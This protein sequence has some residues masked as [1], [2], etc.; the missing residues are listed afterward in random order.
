MSTCDSPL[1][2]GSCLHLWK[3]SIDGIGGVI[4]CNVMGIL[5]HSP[6]FNDTLLPSFLFWCHV[7]LCIRPS[8][9]LLIPQ[10]MKSWVE[11]RNETSI[12]ANTGVLIKAWLNDTY[13]TQ[14]GYSIAWC[15]HRSSLR[16]QCEV[17]KYSY[18]FGDLKYQSRI[19]PIIVALWYL[20]WKAF[21]CWR[22]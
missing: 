19:A 4:C 6:M 13:I 12:S 2:C 3:Y 21:E 7:S 20:R 11:P 17:A 22:Q 14:K 16:L 10:V 5:L 8:C 1:D 9:C 15:I 18:T